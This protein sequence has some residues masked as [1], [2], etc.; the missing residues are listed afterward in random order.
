MQDVE[1]KKDNEVNVPDPFLD[2]LS[3]P[4][5]RGTNTFEVKIWQSF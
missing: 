2:L 1:I 3:V 5:L 4:A